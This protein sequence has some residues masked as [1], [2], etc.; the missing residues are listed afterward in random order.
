[1]D[2]TQKSKLHRFANDKLMFDVVF[3]VLTDVFQREKSQDVHFLAAKSLSVDLLRNGR[4]EIE[5]YKDV[6]EEKLN[7]PHQIGM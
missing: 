1:M 6:E 2:E 7:N 5:K 3:Q 4:R